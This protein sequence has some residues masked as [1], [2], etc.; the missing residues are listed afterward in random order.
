[1]RGKK[2][3]EANNIK[4]PTLS[5]AIERIKRDGG[6]LKGKG[7]GQIVYCSDDEIVMQVTNA[8]EK[9]ETLQELIDSC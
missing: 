6:Y 9:E 2:M 5:D 8:T 1:M 4:Q 3:E 7:N